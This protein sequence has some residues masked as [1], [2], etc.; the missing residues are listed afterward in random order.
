MLLLGVADYARGHL[1][2]PHQP[3]FVADEAA[4]GVGILAASAV[5]LSRLGA[6]PG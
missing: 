2:V 1:G 6:D 5:I 3:D 4:I